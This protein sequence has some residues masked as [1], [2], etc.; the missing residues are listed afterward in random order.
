MVLWLIR[1]ERLTQSDPAPEEQLTK[2]PD[3]TAAE[4][5]I[6]LRIMFSASI[7]FTSLFL[8]V[9]SGLGEVRKSNRTA[10]SKKHRAKTR[11]AG[12]NQ[13]KL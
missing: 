10:T 13:A 1:A 9:L 3:A 7:S 5:I 4:D 12:L 8:P 6:T 2:R 11:L